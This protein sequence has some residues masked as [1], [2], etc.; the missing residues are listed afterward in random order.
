MFPWSGWMLPS[1]GDG[2][3][4]TTGAA[5]LQP[6]IR[7]LLRQGTTAGLALVDVA[8]NFLKGCEWN[9]LEIDLNMF[10]FAIVKFENRK[11]MRVYS[12]NHACYIFIST[13]DLSNNYI[14]NQIQKWSG[15]LAAIRLAI[16]TYGRSSRPKGVQ[17]VRPDVA[18]LMVVKEEHTMAHRHVNCP[19]L[20]FKM[21]AN[22]SLRFT[23]PTVIRHIGPSPRSYIIQD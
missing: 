12:C 8:G 21:V 4:I 14:Q 15:N 20:Q 11:S 2:S 1:L 16:W 3:A 22:A 17:V 9:H 7:T 10:Q 23:S 6:S 13:I 19:C 5:A 18:M